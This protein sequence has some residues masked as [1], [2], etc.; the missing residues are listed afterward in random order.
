MN[1]I[2]FAI[3]GL[4]FLAVVG[5]I[6]AVGAFLTNQSRMRQRLRNLG[7]GRRRGSE[8]AQVDAE[9]AS[10]LQR[11]AEP[12]ARIATPSDEAEVTRFRAKFFNAGIRARSAPIY[13]FAV[14]ALLA[15]ALPLI[16]WIG[17]QLSGIRFSMAVALAFL[18][19]LAAI[20]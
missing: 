17:I 5:V 9:A 14:K 4:V 10:P 18:M 7:I 20:G 1:G 2:E 8:A 3:L 11:I 15:L 13:F 12:M 19:M 16:G 6:A